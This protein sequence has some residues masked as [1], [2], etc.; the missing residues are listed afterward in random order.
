[1]MKA[2]T[3]NDSF[4]VAAMRSFFDQTRAPSPTPGNGNKLKLTLADIIL[5]NASH[6]KSQ[7]Q[8]KGCGVVVSEIGTMEYATQHH[9]PARARFGL[10]PSKE[11]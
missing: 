1:M 6:P 11:R 5:S 7:Q 2:S 3:T 4:Q 10:G 9:G 8:G